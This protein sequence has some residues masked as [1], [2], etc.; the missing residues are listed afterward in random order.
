MSY[1]SE[2]EIAN[3]SEAEGKSSPD[4]PRSNELL[5]Q[6]RLLLRESFSF[7]HTGCPCPLPSPVGICKSESSPVVKSTRAEVR[8]GM[9]QVGINTVKSFQLYRV[10]QS[11]NM[12]SW[13]Q[14]NMAV[15]LSLTP[16]RWDKNGRTGNRIECLLHTRYWIFTISILV[17]M[18]DTIYWC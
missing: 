4:L 14:E 3:S 9:E 17:P 6:M 8:W 11:L 15:V 5:W 2:P 7:K 10:Y 13:P 1:L 16:V 18:A 12:L